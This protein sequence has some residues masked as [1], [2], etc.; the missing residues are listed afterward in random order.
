VLI[1]QDKFVIQKA[2]VNAIWM[3]DN[4][5]HKQKGGMLVVDWW[6]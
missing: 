3:I 6:D 2:N 5:K 4:N 1:A